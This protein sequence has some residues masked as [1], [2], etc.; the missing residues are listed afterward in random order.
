VSCDIFFYNTGARLGID[1]IAEYAKDLSFGSITQI[2]LDGEKAGIVPSTEWASKKQHRKWYPSETISVA[3]GQGPLIV[4]PLQVGVMMAAIANGGTVYRP[5]VVRSIEHMNNDGNVS[6]LK[7]A[8]QALRQLKFRPDVL[9]HVRNGLWKVVNEDG[10]TGGNARVSGL[11][12]CGKT[13]TVQVIAQSGWFSTAGLP[14]MQRDH[15][16]FSSYAKKENPEMVVVVFVEHAGAH[17]GTDSAPLAKMLYEARFQDQVTNAR[18]NLADP[19]TLEALKEGK[20]PQ[21]GVAPKEPAQNDS[22]LG[23]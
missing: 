23:H 16:W 4:T 15:A 18:L 22:G 13:G 7:V 19:E 20:L 14:F 5:H 8:S 9:E 1:K 12:I 3:I 11:D 10:G 21:P 6:R 17:G 2:D